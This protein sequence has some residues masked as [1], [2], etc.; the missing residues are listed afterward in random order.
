MKYGLQGT[1]IEALL[2]SVTNDTC[3]WAPRFLES[4]AL[5]CR[6]SQA[7]CCQ[8]AICVAPKYGR[9][10][11]LTVSANHSTPWQ[12]LLSEAAVRQRLCHCTHCLPA[13]MLRWSAQHTPALFPPP[14]THLR[15][16]TC[17][18]H[19]HINPYTHVDTS[20]RKRIA[21]LQPYEDAVTRLFL[22]HS[23]P[24]TGK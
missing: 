8:F 13:L 22:L 24:L 1:L 15:P 2:S 12:V 5:M 11:Q 23:N 6:C 7:C 10:V 21:R 3:F 20:A 19:T 4:L 17:I 14:N 16:Y 9:P 18:T